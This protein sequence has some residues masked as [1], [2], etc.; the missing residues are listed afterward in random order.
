MKKVMD[1]DIDDDR[2]QVQVT[3]AAST[4]SSTTTTTSAGVV[5]GDSNN[6]NNDD[7]Y[8]TTT[9][10]KREQLQILEES[11]RKVEVPFYKLFCFADFIDIVLMVVGTIAA[12]ANGFC[13]PLQT[14]L[15]GD[16]ANAF[17]LNPDLLHQVSKVPS[18]YS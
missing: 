11:K 18:V 9:D 13:Q 17:G 14:L 3:A 8:S 5:V 7:D 6:N 1:L 15:F 4:R 16:L 12:V 10:N 2:H